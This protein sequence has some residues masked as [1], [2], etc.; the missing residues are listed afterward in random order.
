MPF[1]ID[2]FF[3]EVHVVSG[4]KHRALNIGMRVNGLSVNVVVSVVVWLLVMLVLRLVVVCKA[5]RQVIIVVGLEGVE[6]SIFMQRCVMK[7]MWSHR[8]RKVKLLVVVCVRCLMVRI[9]SWFVLHYVRVMSSVS[10]TKIMYRC[11]G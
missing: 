7:V 1:V 4:I 8:V 3:S 5:G 10:M 11:M 2:R 9:L 6:V